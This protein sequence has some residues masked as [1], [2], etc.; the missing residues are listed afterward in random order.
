[1]GMGCDRSSMSLCGE[2]YQLSCTASGKAM[3]GK[4]K[5][6]EKWGV[7]RKNDVL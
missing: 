4:E 6:K 1:V 2:Y 7:A 5:K 3:P